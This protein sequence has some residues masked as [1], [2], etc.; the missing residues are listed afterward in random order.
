MRGATGQCETV[1]HGSHDFNPHAP[2]G[3]RHSNDGGWTITIPFQSTRPMRGATCHAGSLSWT[4]TFQSTR[5][6]RGA[7]CVGWRLYFR[8]SISIH[9]P[10]AGRDC[11]VFSSVQKI[12]QFQSTRPMRGA[13]H[14]LLIVAQGLGISIHTPHAGRDAGRF[15]RS[16]LPQFQPHAP[17]GARPA[18]PAWAW[19]ALAFQSTR[20]MRGATR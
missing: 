6:M 18:Y 11:I 20:P 12:L 10:H 13:T 8:W 14:V 17:C 16:L 3:A 5:P 2:C 15:R 4:V 7:T 9:T 19:E 1:R